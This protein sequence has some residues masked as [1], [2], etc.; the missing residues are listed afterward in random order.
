MEKNVR[1]VEK[2]RC[3][4]AGIVPGSTP[5]H[6]RA[7]DSMYRVHRVHNS[8]L[9]PGHPRRVERATSGGVRS[10]ARQILVL[11]QSGQY[12]TAP[13]S[14]SSPAMDKVPMFQGSMVALVT[15]M[16]AGVGPATPLADAALRRLLDWHIAEGTEVGS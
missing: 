12:H 8:P 14:G 2:S 16:Q 13:T 6:K 3:R 15:P 5:P 9:A 10:P 4:Q 11:P 7:R 1:S